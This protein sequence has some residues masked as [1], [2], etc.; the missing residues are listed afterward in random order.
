M[1]NRFDVKISL[2]RGTC[3]APSRTTN[4]Y[5]PVAFLYQ[6]AGW[7]DD[8]KGDVAVLRFGADALQDA[9][10]GNASTSSL[11]LHALSDDLDIQISVLNFRMY[12]FCY[13]VGLDI[14]RANRRLN[15]PHD[16]A[17][18]LASVSQPRS[19]FRAI[20]H[21][22]PVKNSDSG[23]GIGGIGSVQN[24]EMVLSL[25]DGE[26]PGEEGVVQSS[27][28]RSSGNGRDRYLAIPSIENLQVSV[29]NFDI[30][31]YRLCRGNGESTVEFS[32]HLRSEERRVGKEC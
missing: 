25:V 13:V 20:R 22:D 16:P 32:R 24:R 23:F 30:E 29:G 27:A 31:H 12:T 28:V 10:T 5:S 14:T 18:A 17:D 26:C 1:W 15:R 9:R 4:V 21:I 3:E 7:A 6:R 2:C 11:G 19:Q 8:H